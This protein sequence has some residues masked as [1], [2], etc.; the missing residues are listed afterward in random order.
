MSLVREASACFSM[1]E[2]AKARELY[3]KAG[4]L[5]GEKNFRV[6]IALCDERISGQGC[7]SSKWGDFTQGSARLLNGYFD[8]VYMVSLE[9][10]V[11]RRLAAGNQLN[12]FGVDFT[13]FPAVNG[14]EG[15]AFRKFEEYTSRKLGDLKRYPAFS[16]KEKK[17]GKP[18]IE[19]AGAIGYIY[20]YINVIKDAKANGFG[21]ILIV[22]DDVILH[23]DF[24]AK[25]KGFVGSICKDWK[26]L[27]LG[28]SQYN[29][30]SVDLKAAEEQGF[31]HPR[32]LDTC[33]SFSI[34]L[35]SSIYDEL[36]E[37]ESAFEGP[38][39][40]LP[41]GEI[42]ERYLGKCFVSY[43]NI[44]MPDVSTSNIRG[45]RCQYQHGERMKW[46]V[47]DFNY[48]LRKPHIAVIVNEER[49]LDSSMISSNPELPFDLSYFRHSSDGLRP[50]HGVSYFANEGPSK[51]DSAN[52]CF[53]V[54]ADY[55]L[56]IKSGCDLTKQDLINFLENAIDGGSRESS[57]IEVNS[58]PKKITRELVS[59]IIPTYKRPNNLR[60][61]LLSVVEQDYPNKEIL[62]VSDN[63][64]DSTYDDETKS[65]VDSVS[66]EF[67]TVDIKLVQHAVN[68]NGAAARN[69]GVMESSGEYICFLD[70]DDIY[71]PG[72]LSKSILALRK[73]RAE[74]GAVYCGF[75]G[76][77]SPKND[78]NRYASGDLTKELLMLDYRKHYLHTNTATYRRSSISKINGFDESYKR[79]QDLEF[80]LRFFKYFE[81]DVVP[82]ALVRLN[83]EPSSV[84][85]KLF[86]F[87]FCILKAKFL[88]DF[89]DACSENG[90]DFL[91]KVYDVH[92][93]EIGRYCERDQ[94]VSGLLSLPEGASGFD[95]MLR[96]ILKES[97]SR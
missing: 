91:S 87:D 35:D 48:P 70:D 83:P 69:T 50:I 16:E 21:R 96:R 57:G 80:N 36:I 37:A 14:Y 60:N 15:D 41:L 73:S 1:G 20:T 51:V 4:S 85:N 24:D 84:S 8:H 46:Q 32:L 10:D 71:L 92:W 33:G 79:H 28:A 5:L 9:K 31:Y 54:D 66:N 95:W 90:S 45:G 88:S 53:E 82:E 62:V 11:S 43:P 22:E 13:V 23:P 89:F 72:R 17:R 64:R 44:V 7:D 2:Y 74:V 81:I 30:S 63:G 25:F 86:G 27:Q 52:E 55:C 6:N 76:W 42:Y 65:I 26:I 93:G 56:T 3:V 12:S 94:I 77:N 67:P 61:A 40:H 59:V 29:W 39:D 58:K 68:R 78:V 34:A 97:F 38:F 47:K 75:L 19:S 49:N 18:Y